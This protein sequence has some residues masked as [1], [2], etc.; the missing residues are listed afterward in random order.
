[1]REIIKTEPNSNFFLCTDDAKTKNEL[2][3]IFQERVVVNEIENYD[4]SK[5]TAIKDAAVDLYCLAATKKIF[6]SH[7]SSFS[8]TAADIGKI[9]EVTVK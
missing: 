3:E 9:E 2:L 6:G 1:M 4:R 5:A 7:H 8:Q